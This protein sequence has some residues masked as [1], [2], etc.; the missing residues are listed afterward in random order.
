MVNIFLKVTIKCLPLNYNTKLTLFTLASLVY[1]K[2]K[3]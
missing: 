3:F 1:N 2:T